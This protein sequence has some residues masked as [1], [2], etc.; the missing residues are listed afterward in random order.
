MGRGELAL[1]QEVFTVVWSWLR[2]NFGRV[3]DDLC[4]V[5]LGAGHEDLSISTGGPWSE[6]AAASSPALQAHTTCVV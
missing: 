6:F 2:I 4:E 5:S 3:W 1:N